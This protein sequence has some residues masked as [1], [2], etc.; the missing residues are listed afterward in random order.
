MTATARMRILVQC[1]RQC[2]VMSQRHCDRGFPATRDI[3]TAICRTAISNI[4]RQRITAAMRDRAGNAGA[5]AATRC[6]ELSA[7][8]FRHARAPKGFK[9]RSA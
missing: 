4:D 8:K 5:P 9:H 3:R 7:A 6:K 1:L 2:Y